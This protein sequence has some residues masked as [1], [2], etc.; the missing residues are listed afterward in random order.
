MLS[1]LSIFVAHF[2]VFAPPEAG[3]PQRSYQLWADFS[4]DD[5]F[6]PEHGMM[7]WSIRIR[8]R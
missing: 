3:E 2:S 7:S 8:G 1:S 4:I 6:R 5:G